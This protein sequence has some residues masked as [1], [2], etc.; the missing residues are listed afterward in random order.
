MGRLLGCGR[1]I[2]ICG[3]DE[4]CSWLTGELGFSAAINYKKD[5][6]ATKLKELCPE[7]VQIY[8]D[9]VGGSISDMV[10]T[11]VNKTSFITVNVQAAMPNFI[12]DDKKFTCDI[13]W[14]NCNLQ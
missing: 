8:F 9:N 3:S 5:N 2:G 13:M 7:G 6:V 12:V 1:V 14:T 11:Q 4:K 10:I